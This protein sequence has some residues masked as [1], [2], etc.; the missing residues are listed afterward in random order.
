MNW[1]EIF[2]REVVH[3]IFST[4]SRT[5]SGIYVNKI[6]PS[7]EAN[8]FIE[9]CMEEAKKRGVPLF[10][11]KRLRKLAGQVAF[12]K[13]ENEKA[14]LQ[15]NVEFILNYPW[16]DKNNFIL[17]DEEMNQ[18]KVELEANFAG[19]KG[20]V[21][22]IFLYVIA[23]SMTKAVPLSLGGRQLPTLCIVGPDSSDKDWIVSVI[24]R[25]LHRP[26]VRAKFQGTY[27]KVDFE[28]EPDGFGSCRARSPGYFANLF[29]DVGASN[30][31]ML[32]D[33]V[34][35]IP[36]ETAETLAEIL[37]NSS[38]PL[39][40]YLGS[41]PELSCSFIVCSAKDLFS[42]HPEL[43]SRLSYFHISEISEEDKINFAQKVLVERSARMSGFPLENSN[44]SRSAL[45][46]ILREY[47]AGRGIEDF[48]RTLVDLFLEAR[49]VLE[50]SDIAPCLDD[51]GIRKLLGSNVVLH[52]EGMVEGES[53]DFQ[54]YGEELVNVDLNSFKLS[55]IARREAE[56]DLEQIRSA[57]GLERASCKKHLEWLLSLPWGKMQELKCEGILPRAR[58]ILDEDHYGIKDVKERVLDYLAVGNRNLKSPMIL[59]LVGP[60]GVGK[61]SIAKSIARCMGR[62]FER[63]S[64]GGVWNE[65]MIR[66][67]E[68]SYVD[69][70]PG[71]IIKAFK[72]SGVLNPLI[73]LDEIDKLGTS[74][75]HGDPY[76]ALL[77]V[78]DPEQNHTFVD[79]F[80][81]V[82]F[83]LS[84]AVFIVTANSKK[85]I[86]APLLD[87]LEIIDLS[88]YTL[89]EK[90]EIAERHLIP[91][92]LAELSISKEENV[93]RQ[94]LKKIVED[95]TFEAGVRGLKKQ[96][97]KLYEKKIRFEL[98][99]KSVS[100]HCNG[101]KDFLGVSRNRRDKLSRRARI[102]VVN[103]LAYCS[104]DGY[105]V[106]GNAH[107][108]EALFVPR[109]GELKVSRLKIT[110]NVGDMWQ[111]AANTAMSYLRGNAKKFG[112]PQ[113]IFTNFDLHVHTPCWGVEGPS[114]G[115][116]T[117]IAI[118]SA[119]TKRPI[120][121][122]WAMT[123]E[124]DL[125][126][127]VGAIG[128]VR[129]KVLG[130]IVAGAT[131]VILPEE[132]RQDW[133]EVKDK[134]TG[135]KIHFVSTFDE[136]VK[137]VLLK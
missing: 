60:P 74:S 70:A 24:A 79:S 116:A 62:K 113:N 134:F 120:R 22:K 86:P 100:L 75:H 73:L 115:A 16:E 28:G 97:K 108:V 14:V 127:H 8:S 78:L 94:I 20:L 59:C 43:R 80:L 68:R 34:D 112:I 131:N 119:A 67:W 117:T 125:Y 118:L 45:K 4:V 105:G 89:E 54:P 49:R 5:G 15:D 13:N 82:P 63:I 29:Y 110:G 21:D 77:E 12:A 130:A 136:I 109:K 122:D 41:A 31:V 57:Y 53:E 42:I 50:S 46:I 25:V 137:L 10:S 9:K 92:I 11:Q 6:L 124:I 26:F 64:L 56:R 55:K 48:A 19:I 69:S 44:I 32:W 65:S 123:G 23:N 38:A 104:V 2:V 133:E 35:E 51:E 47:V 84:K 101:L 99:G 106:G 3:A 95:Y 132:N 40:K 98:E 83:D 91:E 128:G 36:V 129:G 33:R 76:A 107:K 1:K 81:G 58:K 121:G 135:I 88:G 85:V 7:L 90:I 39:D 71:R 17:S 126:G 72:S 96:L 18:F 87:R 61:T 66:G 102:G 30:P 103:A 37:D 93:S 111:D 114:A 27:N 52:N